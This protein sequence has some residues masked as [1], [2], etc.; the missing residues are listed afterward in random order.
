MS[1]A[2]KIKALI[3]LL[4]R[5]RVA[6]KDDEEPTVEVTEQMDNAVHDMIEAHL[7]AVRDFVQT[8]YGLTHKQAVKLILD[9]LKL[10][11]Q[12]GDAVLGVDDDNT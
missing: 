5:I 7:T 1:K 3:D 4:E 6:A 10:A 12:A 11:V 8:A 2:E 9:D